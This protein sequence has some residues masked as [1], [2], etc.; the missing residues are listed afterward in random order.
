MGAQM[1]LRDLRYF[2]TIAEF[3][4]V[5]RAAKKLCRT[6]PTLTGCVR[7]LE[8]VFGT[9]LFERVGRGI[10]LTPAGEALLVRA[11]RLRVAADETVQEIHDVA[12]G[13]AGHIRI[14]VVPTG[15]QD[16]LP[17]LCRAFLAEAKGV[18]LKTTIAQNDA[19][20]ALLQSGELDLL[21]SAD[22]QNS[23]EFVSHPILKD[24]VVV[25]ASSGHE[26]FRRRAKMQD[27]LEYDW[28]L[29]A[30][31]VDT[32][33][34]L[35]RAFDRAG[36]PRPHVKIETNLVLLL[37]PLI[38]ETGLLSFISRSHLAAGRVGSPLKEV[39]MKE[40]TMPRAFR[41]I[42]RKDGYLP[43]AARRLTALVSAKG[44]KA[45]G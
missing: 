40:T 7:R 33:Q 39:P 4:H 3:G 11:R 21:I 15:A 41:L 43:P 31:S 45:L 18:T 12:K 35:D 25:V 1:D 19:L 8:A 34:W 30:P 27:L 28:V 32:R 42:Y 24:E 5:G 37:P 13:D 6:Q 26:V 29:A 20:I 22:P 10:R 17:D 38:V 14:G 16:L 44:A 23:R 9:P 2:E 36:L